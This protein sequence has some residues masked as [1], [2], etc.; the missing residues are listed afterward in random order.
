MIKKNHFPAEADGRSQ[1]MLSVATG[2]KTAAHCLVFCK[3]FLCCC[4]V[5]AIIFNDEC[6][7]RPA[8]VSSLPTYPEADGGIK[9]HITHTVHAHIR[10]KT[11]CIIYKCPV[12]SHL[13]GTAS[14]S[15][16]YPDSEQC[17]CNTSK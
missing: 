14:L 11:A 16:M 10:F 13:Y 8:L 4:T 3:T 9:G 17:G 1:D 2:N 7:H 5:P 6:Q 15:I 12:S